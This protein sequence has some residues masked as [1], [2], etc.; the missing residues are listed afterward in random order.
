[1][2]NFLKQG[3]RQQKVTKDKKTK[4]HIKSFYQ[5][6]GKMD[7]IA[8]QLDSTLEYTEDN[9]DEY[10]EPI[11]DRKLDSM[12]KMLVLGKLHYKKEENE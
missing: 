2:S 12:E 6:L 10:V 5:I 7:V 1:M 11:L 9:I 8:N 4:K 3:L